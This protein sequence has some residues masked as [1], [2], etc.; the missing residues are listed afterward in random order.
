MLGSAPVS[1]QGLT[2]RLLSLNV[3]ESGAVAP[4]DQLLRNRAVGLDL[5]DAERDILGRP[6]L[7]AELLSSSL[8]LG[9]RDLGL[10][11]F[12]IDRDGLFGLAGRRGR[13]C[14]RA[15]SSHGGL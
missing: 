6:G 8:A 10:D 13:G 2:A 11:L 14:S 1:R 12:A 5:H 3:S 4:I 15:G 7:G 9:A